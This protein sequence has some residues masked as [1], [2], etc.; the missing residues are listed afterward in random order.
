MRA[1]A[2]NLTQAAYAP[3]VS[4]KTTSFLAS[5]GWTAHIHR[6][7]WQKQ[8]K[9]TAHNFWSSARSSRLSVFYSIKATPP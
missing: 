9:C 6:T 4:A 7:T 3:P 2:R 1:L 8:K 5:L